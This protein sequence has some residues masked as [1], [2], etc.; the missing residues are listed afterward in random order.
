MANTATNFNVDPY[1]DD[2]DE[3]KNF[4]RVLFKPGQA[5]QARE[6][7]QMQTIL[8][9]QI[10]R[11]GDHIFEEGSHVKGGELTFNYDHKFIKLANTM[12]GI[13]TVT[14]FANTT[15]RGLTSNA[16]ARVIDTIASIDTDPP[17]LVVR[18]DSGDSVRAEG[19]LTSA[20]SN[21]TS[22]TIGTGTAISP[23]SSTNDAY[24]HMSI[25][26]VSGTGARQE[27]KIID[28]DGSSRRVQ[29]ES[30]LAILP[31]TTTQ[32]RIY[33]KRGRFYDGETIN[34]IANNGI[35]WGSSK[36]P[37]TTI[38]S[39][40]EPFGNTCILGVDEGI[41][42]VRGAFVKFA[43]EKITVGKYTDKPT[44]TVGLNIVESTITSTLDTKLL[45]PAQGSY[46]YAAP[47]ADRWKVALSLKANN[48]LPGSNNSSNNFIELV[49]FNK[50][51]VEQSKKYAVYSDL[52]K[53]DLR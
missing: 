47:G 18:V 16:T 7:T 45:D 9:N 10:E 52:A 44:K 26:L 20:A 24:N 46:N 37:N 53:K 41:F 33:D 2:F 23:T 11:F 4:H 35:A 6:L 50:G 22:M 28:Y 27:R 49:R 17:T 39:T 31:D 13:A 32:Y 15:I 51:T 48:T 40:G 36:F 29:L 5:V 25:S 43:A 42:Y 14:A 34:V 12:P 1:Y 21:L 3:S 30:A 38:A 8:Q 19:V